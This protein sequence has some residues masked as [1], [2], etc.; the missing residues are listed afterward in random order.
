MKK[1]ITAIL[2]ILLLTIFV[3]TAVPSTTANKNINNSQIGSQSLFWESVPQVETAITSLVAAGN[4]V[5]AGTAGQGVIHWQKDTGAYERITTADGLPHNSVYDIALDT[6]NNLWFGTGNGIAR[7]DGTT[8]TTYTTANGLPHSIVRAIF[9]HPATGEII[10][11]AATGI[12]IFNGTSWTGLPAQPSMSVVDFV[13]D[14]SGVYWIAVNAGG[15]FRYDGIWGY[16]NDPNSGPG[17]TVTGVALNPLNGDIWFSFEGEGVGRISDNLYYTYT[18]TNGLLNNQTNTIGVDYAGQVWV[19]HG[20]SPFDSNRGLSRFVGNTW[21]PYSLD[22]GIP[23]CCVESVAF[24]TNGDRWFGHFGA[25]VLDSGNWST[26][27]T[28]PFGDTVSD[29]AVGNNNQIWFGQ[30]RRGAG[31]LTGRRWAY[32]STYDGL[33]GYTVSDVAVD[34]NNHAWLVLKTGSGTAYKGLNRY[35][36]QNWFY[37]TQANSNLL[38]NAITDIYPNNNGATWF[39]TSQG[40]SKWTGSA[41]TS[42]TSA[43]GLPNN[44]IVAIA[45]DGN[46]VWF[47]L[48]QPLGQIVHY[49]GTTVTIYTEPGDLGYRQHFDMDIGPTGDLWLLSG[50]GNDLLVSQ[51]NG[52]WNHI[53]NVPEGS[54]P[55]MVVDANNTPWI[56]TVKE[57]IYHYNGS[58][59]DSYGANTGLPTSN[60]YKISRNDT[61]RTIWFAGQTG[62]LQLQILTGLDNKA[63]VPILEGN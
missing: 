36:G 34:S 48:D 15:V 8:W 27:G 30:W 33:G 45:A 12:V 22:Q 53:T 19:G 44:D 35:D 7:Y 6:A 32:V 5:W 49:D 52:G 13:V 50:Q 4:D 18:T 59:W 47:A 37:Y 46:D 16:F 61:R 56:S 2:F 54:T 42:F 40:A 39:A 17:H 60:F 57:G 28:G 20:N 10:A 21:I 62:L 23:V 51:F 11:G 24:N 3:L 25:T 43:N 26:Y 14:L 41:F 38:S 55:F 58:S 29:V 31:N 9:I 1:T 63:Y